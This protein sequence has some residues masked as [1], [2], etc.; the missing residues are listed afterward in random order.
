MC[1][2][3][4]ACV[5]TTTIALIATA[6]AARVRR[7]ERYS[8]RPVD[9][10]AGGHRTTGSRFGCRRLGGPRPA[11]RARRAIIRWA[12]GGRW[13]RRR[14]RRRRSDDRRIAAAGASWARARVYNNVVFGGWGDGGL[15]ARCNGRAHILITRRARGAGRRRVVRWSGWGRGDTKQCIGASER[16]QRTPG[17]PSPPPPPHHHTRHINP[18]SRCLSRPPPTRPPP[19][20]PAPT[21]S[22]AA[23]MTTTA[24]ATGRPMAARKRYGPPV[25]PG[26]FFAVSLE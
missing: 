6:A 19:L 20:K 4:R 9:T 14:R 23:A 5:L 7:R 11:H 2:R 8:A 25:R 22:T 12:G 21:T 15:G 17:P 3:R 1:R 10:G 13:Q 18:L 24:T 26:D 16:G